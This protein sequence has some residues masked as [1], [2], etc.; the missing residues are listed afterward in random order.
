MDEV[1]RDLAGRRTAPEDAV[2]PEGPGRALLE[3]RAAD[4][5]I[6]DFGAVA[7]GATLNTAAI[8]QAIDRAAEEK[9]RVVVPTGVFKTGAIFLKQGAA[10]HFEDGAVLAG[11]TDLADYPKQMTRIEGHFEPWRMALVNAADMPYML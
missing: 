7:D 1:G 5:P 8:Q 3:A 4:F 2:D 6:T 11:S 10:L 9:G